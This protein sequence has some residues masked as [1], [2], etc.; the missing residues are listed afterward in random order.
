MELLYNGVF[1]PIIAYAA[2]AWMD[3][4]TRPHVR[5]ALL[6]AQRK[7]MLT[8]ARSTR[9]MATASLQ[10]LQGRLPADLLVARW[11]LRYC[12]SRGIKA[13]VFGIR[14]DEGQPLHGKDLQCRL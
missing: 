14:L 1:Q 12:A 4:L 5:S 10:V 13:D 11:G 7:L 3:Q 8:M 9:S 2:G 6:A